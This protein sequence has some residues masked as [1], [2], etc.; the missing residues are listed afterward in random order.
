[1]NF[2]KESE[3]IMKFFIDDFHKFLGKKN[4]LKQR[5]LDNILGILYNEIKLSSRWTEA[6]IQ[7]N[8]VKMLMKQNKKSAE[9]TPKWL[10]E[11]SRFVPSEIVSYI[12][13][14]IQGYLIYSLKIEDRDIQIFFALLHD[15]DINA[16]G[17]FDKYVAKM[18]IWL[19]I[20][21]PQAPSKCGRKIKIYCFLTPFMKRLPVSPFETLSAKNCNS[22]VTTSCPTT[23]EIVVY[24]KEEFLK[25]FMHESFHTLG[26]D[27]ST[28]PLSVF[29]KAVKGVFPIKSEFNLFEAYA[30][31]WASVM[32]SL[33]TAYNTIEDKDD[34]ESFLLYGEFCMRF[35]QLFSLFQSVKVLDFM[36]L[37]YNNLYDADA[38]S[39]GAR[40]YLFK[41]D[42]NVFAYYIIKNILLYNNLDF[43]SWC[44]RHNQNILA[45]NKTHSNL[46]GFLQF[47][48]SHYRNPKYIDDIKNMAAFL[49]KIQGKRAYPN[50]GLLTSTM[51]MSVC[52]TD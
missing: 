16:V 33:L 23:G 4:L 38:L 5:K 34:K 8:K 22:A 3:D 7:L 10:E 41:E 27:F 49:E 36:G 19:K 2:T 17:K 46:E 47:I 50:H 45:F 42:T 14:H 51:R 11:D 43:L 20:A 13:S 30:E 6:Q 26:L 25:V 1:M 12:K 48:V 29:N 28:M 44:R 40:R 35:E 52:E 15:S 39:S 32:N 31:F 18:M 9:I 37:T 21:I 24:R